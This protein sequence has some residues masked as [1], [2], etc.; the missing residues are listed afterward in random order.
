VLAVL[1]LSHWFL[2]VPMHRPDLPLWPGSTVKVGFGLWNSLAATLL[3][4]LGLLLVGV[5]LYA[6]ATRARDGIGRWGLLALVL[7][8]VG[9]F[10]GAGAGTPPSDERAVALGALVL[11]LLV[12]WGWWVDRHREP[13]LAA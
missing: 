10:A 7:F 8:L 2:D 9:G 5:T 11:W 1:V 13:V 4:E 3:I 6:R 12:P